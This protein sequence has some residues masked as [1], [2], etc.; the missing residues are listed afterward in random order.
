M[1]RSEH[2]QIRHFSVNF[3]FHCVV[4]S[5]FP[6]AL[7]WNES[8]KGGEAQFATYI[9]LLPRELGNEAMLYVASILLCIG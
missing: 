4:C 1:C 5:L 2:V 9:L 8:D 6:Q 7:G 3:S